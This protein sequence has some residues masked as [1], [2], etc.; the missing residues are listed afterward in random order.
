M[1]GKEKMSK[2]E[3]AGEDDPVF[4]VLLRV[5]EMNYSQFLSDITRQTEY[6]AQEVVAMMAVAMGGVAGRLQAEYAEHAK[7]C[8]SC[9]AK[10]K[11]D[12]RELFFRNF[13]ASY[14]MTRNEVAETYRERE[15]DA[16]HLVSEFFNHR[17]KK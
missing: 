9:A 3:K 6:E 17:A 15:K 16:A 1:K 13:S 8:E 14:S 11:W 4:Q 5:M 7:E 2:F 12:L 10:S